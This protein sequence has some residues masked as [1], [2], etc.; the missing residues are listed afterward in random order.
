MKPSLLTALSRLPLTLLLAL[1]CTADLITFNAMTA[2]ENEAIRQDWLNQI[3]IVDP[4]FSIDFEDSFSDGQD[5]AKE[6]LSG[7]LKMTSEDSSIIITNNSGLLGS[8][9]PVGILS[10]SFAENTLVTLDFSANPVAYVS[11]V[12]ID[13]LGATYT[14]TLDDDESIVVKGETTA[15]SGES[16]EF[17]GFYSDDNRKITQITMTSEVG[18]NEWGIDSLLFGNVQVLYVDGNTS[19][20]ANGSSWANAFHTLQDALAVATPPTSVLIAEGLYF[21]DKGSGQ[22][23]DNV[24]STFAPPLGTS[25]FGGFPQGGAPFSERNAETN[26]TILSGRLRF[27]TLPGEELFAQ[28]VISII[29]PDEPGY[30]RALRY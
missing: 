15:S 10:A 14:I 5:I 17:V 12:E 29:E 1:P 30:L 21:P 26:Q 22:T 25:L 19:A 4:Q 7:G 24:F 20:T 23:E 11:F 3:Q 13:T 6:P 16:A 18:D 9:Q 28:H 27:M 2:D 8:S